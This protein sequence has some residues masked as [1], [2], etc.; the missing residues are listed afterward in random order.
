MFVSICRIDLIDICAGPGEL[1]TRIHPEIAKVVA[2]ARYDVAAPEAR[3]KSERANLE[4]LLIIIFLISGAEI[5]RG[6]R[7]LI[8]DT[9]NVANFGEKSLSRI[10]IKTGLGVDRGIPPGIGIHAHHGLS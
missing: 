8:C 5:A 7:Q 10:H 3:E 6:A 4:I 9:R 2:L 1:K